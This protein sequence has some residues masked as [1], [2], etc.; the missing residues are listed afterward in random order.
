[1]LLLLLSFMFFFYLIALYHVFNLSACK[2]Y[3]FGSSLALFIFLS[4]HTI[5]IL[6]SIY[7]CLNQ[8][9]WCCCCCYW[10]IIDQ[11]SDNHTFFVLLLFSQCCQ[12]F[13]NLLKYFY[14][15]LFLFYFV[16][17]YSILSKILVC[18][19]FYIFLTEGPSII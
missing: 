6:Y 4:I 14:M 3:Y 10:L 19:L 2:N 15:M 8:C 13:V 11:Y 7:Y 18:D 1:M 12:H 9:Y 5:I 16:V 17:L